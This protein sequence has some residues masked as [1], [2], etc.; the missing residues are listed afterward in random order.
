MRKTA[1]ETNGETLTMYDQQATYKELKEIHPSLRTVNAQVL[2]NV[3]VR[4]DLGMKAFFR[5]IRVQA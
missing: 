5:R 1:Y 3:A 2:Q 4:L